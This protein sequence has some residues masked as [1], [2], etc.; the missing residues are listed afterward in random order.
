MPLLILLIVT[1]TCV[2]IGFTYYLSFATLSLACV[3]CLWPK[4]LL[5]GF[6]SHPKALFV[7]FAFFGVF[8]CYWTND[9]VEVDLFEEVIR[10][11]REVIMF[12]L[13]VAFLRGASNRD[14]RAS[15]KH[16]NAG[17]MFLAVGFFLLVI[18]QLRFLSSGEYFGLPREAFIQNQMTIPTAEDVFWSKIRPSGTFG[19]PSYLA[20][21]LVSILLMVVP[22]LTTSRIGQVVGCL[23]ALTGLMTESGSFLVALCLLV[24]VGLVPEMNTTQK[25]YA[26]V[27]GAP[28]AAGVMLWFSSDVAG[29][30]VG[31]VRDGSDLSLGIRLLGPVSILPEFLREYPF[32]VFFSLN[33][34]MLQR[35]FPDVFVQY[36]SVFDNALCNVFFGH[37]ILAVPILW[38][39][40][41]AVQSSIVRLYLFICMSFNGMI[42]S[43][44]KVA[45][46]CI[47]VVVFYSRLRGEERF[48]RMRTASA[49]I[50][51][52]VR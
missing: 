39:V 30:L 52:G 38:I 43:V 41:S 1:F 16:L 13:V 10:T 37:G 14:T 7:A 29:R 18:V 2:Q 23:V 9:V 40:F 21:I 19:E 25:L 50:G 45:V 20:F 49:V 31:F 46:I 22:I 24:M 17:L 15:Q 48:R 36:G 6:L 4:C 28:V 12:L 11:C 3:V 47:S 44:D 8:A 34:W 33:G 5:A 51:A 35:S 32:G 27:V 26:G 42:F